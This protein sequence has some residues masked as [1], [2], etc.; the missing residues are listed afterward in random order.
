MIDSKKY[1]VVIGGATIDISGYCDTKVVD[2]TSNPGRVTLAAGG[3]GRNIAE[4]LVRLDV[5]TK[6][7]SALGNDQLGRSTLD[8]CKQIG[9]DCTHLKMLDGVASSIV[10]AI[11]DHDGRMLHAVAQMQAAEAIDCDFIDN[12]AEIINQAQVIVLD[13]NLNQKTLEHICRKFPDSA[14]FIDPVSVKK[15]ERIKALLPSIHTIKANRLEAE[16]L[17]D[18]T[19]RNSKDYQKAVVDFLEIGVRQVCISLGADG[20]YY[21]NATGCAQLPAGKIEVVSDTGA[22]DAFL[23]ALV[24]GYLNDDEL[25]TSC[26]FAMAAAELTLSQ[27]KMVHPALSRELIYE[28]MRQSER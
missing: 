5:P 21:G 16:A 24:V 8:D 15:S 22:G 19:L 10:L 1:V 13:A 11:H 25:P 27:Q 14:I 26:R 18:R 9:I 2:F 17:L 12:Q 6:L 4:N 28:R 3:V 20:V 23:A 7:L